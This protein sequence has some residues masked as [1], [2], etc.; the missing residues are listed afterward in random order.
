MHH[1]KYI[2]MGVLDLNQLEI[3]WQLQ[4]HDLNLKSLETNLEDLSKKDSIKV[5]KAKLK[6]L[7][8][9]LDRRNK[10]IVE[11]EKALKK[12]DKELQGLSY[13]L[14]EIDK[15]LYNGN[16][17]DLKQL[18]Y[19]D[20]ESNRLKKLINEQEVKA[21]SLMEK[22]DNTQNE[23]NSDKI[24]CEKINKQFDDI[25][26]EHEYLMGELK[27]KIDKEIEII[28]SISS[29]IDKD[30]LEKY[31]KLKKTKNVPIAKVVKDECS[32]CHMIISFNILQRLNKNEC[33]V[34]CENCGRILYLEVPE[35]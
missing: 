3:L 13:E 26:K 7:E 10:S 11:N 18:S 22:I 33:I 12:C 14:G 30:I 28:N 6:S 4:D 29:N 9:K 8:D 34:Q 16:I 31:L 23:I 25:A 32:G 27:L 19:L 20:S 2:K 17:T 24:K 21:L 15:Q 5:L 35:E 1:L